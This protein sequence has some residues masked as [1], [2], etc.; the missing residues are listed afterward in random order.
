MRYI[1][2]EL[3]KIMRLLQKELR[4]ELKQQGHVN[5]GA[6][7]DSIVY[8]VKYTDRGFTATMYAA[9]YA[10]IVDLGVKANRIPYSGRSGNGG[11][12]LY[13]Q[14]LVSFFQRKGLG[15][16]EALGAAFATAKVHSRD[17]M[18]SRASFRFSRNGRRTG[19]VTE[20]I[21]GKTEKLGALIREG[22]ATQLAVEFGREFKLEPLKI[23]A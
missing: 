1:G 4:K 3:T 6:L 20:V 11:T 18:P 22:I 21:N 23:V 10:I 15:E 5:T 16:K 7:R 14:G 13:I 8:E 2:K 19:F 17:G 9:D 12:S